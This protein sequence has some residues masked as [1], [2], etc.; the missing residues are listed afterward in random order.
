MFCCGISKVTTK[1]N[2]LVLAFIR[3]WKA[4]KNAKQTFVQIYQIY[5]IS[6][7]VQQRTTLHPLNAP[8]LHVYLIWDSDPKV[9]KAYWYH[10]TA[11]KKTLSE[12]NIYL[13]LASIWMGDTG[14]KPEQEQF[15]EVS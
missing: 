6:S 7:R 2:M 14:I 12:G 5:Q 10:D 15:S 11:T 3:S 1:Y 9:E 8:P 13:H 4:N